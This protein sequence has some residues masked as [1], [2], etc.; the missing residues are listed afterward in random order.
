MVTVAI[1]GARKC[2]SCGEFAYAE[3]DGGKHTRNDPY[4]G[5]YIDGYDDAGKPVCSWCLESDWEH[6][7]TILVFEP[8]HPEPF[9]FVVGDYVRSGDGP[10]GIESIV[11]EFGRPIWHSTDAWRGHYEFTIPAGYTSVGDGGW[12]TSWATPDDPASAHKMDLFELEAALRTSLADLTLP[13]R[14][15]VLLT[16]TSNVFSQGID[17]V[18]ADEDRQRFADW[19]KV[20]AHMTVRDLGRAMS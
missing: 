8:G 2:V 7:S 13:C 6:S 15:Y 17:V 3:Y 14:I 9:Q 5:R 16:K 11:E 19:L 20:H 18:V 12:Y 1:A 4:Q 10:W